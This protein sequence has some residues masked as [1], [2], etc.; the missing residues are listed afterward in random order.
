MATKSLDL[1]N[2][3]QYL[4]DLIKNA[5]TDPG[6][7]QWA[8][9][10]AQTYASQYPGFSLSSPYTG[11]QS[12]SPSSSTLNSIVNYGTNP[13]GGGNIV[14]DSQGT[15]YASPNGQWYAVGN[16]PGMGQV[17]TDSSG[18]TWY[19]LGQQSYSVGPIP[20]M[21]GGGGGVGQGYAGYSG[22]YVSP[23]SSQINALLSKLNSM[24]AF[25]PN[26]VYS[27]P[28]YLAMQESLNA[29][30]QKTSA[31]VLAQAA[32]NTGGIASSY[33]VAAAKESAADVKNR[34]NEYIPSLTQ[35]AY[36]R[37]LQ[38]QGL[39][40]DQINMLA[41]LENS[42]YQQFADQRNFG[43]SVLESNRNYNQALN[44]YNRSIYESDRNFNY[45]VG[46][47]KL[48]DQRW[49]DQWDYQQRQDALNYGLKT[50]SISLDERNAA[51][52]RDK[53]AWEK[54]PTNPANMK[55]PET[56]GALYGSMFNSGDPE[57]WLKDNATYL[58][59]DELKALAGYL[60]NSE[61]LKILELI[62]KK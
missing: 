54:D 10:Q 9:Q 36:N 13:S 37:Y 24:P 45:Q 42:G 53:F 26:S 25:N 55:E 1:E 21:S 22:Q 49:L 38:E 5:E 33:A 15:W 7:A 61:A 12:S 3:R 20:G 52:A 48:M 29:Q 2:E 59:D 23:Y 8:A 51:L 28:E 11:G 4:I 50:R 18:Q 47:D 14:T 31:D 60:P 16:Q 62:L 57:K 44:E 30:S 58:N 35:A 41:S 56:I 27:S 19:T 39:T 43:Q 46:R 34:L 32:G 6:N 17:S 40:L